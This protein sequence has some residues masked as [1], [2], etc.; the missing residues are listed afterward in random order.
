MLTISALVS[1]L[2]FTLRVLGSP[3]PA[4]AHTLDAR[5]SVDSSVHCGQWDTVTAGSYSLLLDLWG[6]SGATSGSQ[7]ANLVSLDGSTVAWTTNWTWSGG[8]GVKTF[9]D[10]Q[11]NQGIGTQLSKIKSMPVG[12]P[13]SFYELDDP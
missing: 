4:H 6:E 7:C 5:A 3:A 2:P 8:N 10:I 1:L 13:F 12:L 9:T 11:L